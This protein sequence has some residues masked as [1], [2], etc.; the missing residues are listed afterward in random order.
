VTSG[1][2]SSNDSRTGVNRDMAWG[3]PSLSKRGPRP[4]GNDRCVTNR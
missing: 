3:I 4:A 2:A 1:A